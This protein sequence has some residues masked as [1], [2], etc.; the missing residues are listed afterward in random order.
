[1]QR[2]RACLGRPLPSGP[3][4]AASGSSV[5]RLGGRGE[6]EMWT[7]AHR[8]RHEAPEGDGVGV[9]DRGD[10]ALAGAGR[11]TAL[12]PGDGVAGG[13]GSALLASAGRR[14]MA[15]AARRLAAVADGLRLVP[16]LARTGSVRCPAGRRRPAAAARGGTVSRA[17][18]GDHRHA[19]RQGHRRARAARLGRPQEGARAQAC[20]AG[21]C[22]RL[23][24]RRCGRAG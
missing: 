7:K 1:M 15:G 17:T 3:H 20:G 5:I 14:A 2:L 21:R 8:A 12:G 22:R 16:A 24:A 23:L 19:E 9:R 6:G 11:S 13:G 18:A 10:G 4:L